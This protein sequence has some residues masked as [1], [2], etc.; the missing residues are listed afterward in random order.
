MTNQV[1]FFGRIIAFGALLA[2]LGH[3]EAQQ[4]STAPVFSTTGPDAAAYGKEQGYPLGTR[5]TTGQ[6]QH[7]VAAYSQFDQL[8][9]T[10]V[11]PRAAKPWPYRR[12]TTRT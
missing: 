12:A 8:F 1:A 10:R 5:A 11:V 2:L 6:V 3:A 4:A 9:A 7:L